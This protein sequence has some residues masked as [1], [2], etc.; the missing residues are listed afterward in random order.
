VAAAIVEIHH[1]PDATIGPFL[2]RIREEV[3]VV[4]LLYR[5]HVPVRRPLVNIVVCLKG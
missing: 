3:L 2:A 1:D 5:S 4:V